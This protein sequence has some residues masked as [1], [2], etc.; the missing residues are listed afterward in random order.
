MAKDLTGLRVCKVHI[1]R[2]GNTTEESQEVDF[3]F[4]RGEGIALY[5]VEFAL[6]PV[7]TADDDHDSRFGFVSLH[8][9]NDALEQTFDEISGEAV[10]IDSEIIAEATI[11]CLNQDEAATRGGSAAAYTWMSPNFWNFMEIHGR[12]IILATNPTFRAQV[13]DAGLV[14][15][16]LCTM[17]YKYVELSN[18]EIRDAFFRAR[19]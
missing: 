10:E 12:P 11:V 8:A 17:Y 2:A 18:A 14:M 6:E 5:R 1:D 9:E 3:D 4:G 19:G 16:G 7:V 13:S 15:D